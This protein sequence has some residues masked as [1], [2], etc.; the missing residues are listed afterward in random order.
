MGANGHFLKGYSII[1]LAGAI[2]PLATSLMY[3]NARQPT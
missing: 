2:F 3:N 1:W